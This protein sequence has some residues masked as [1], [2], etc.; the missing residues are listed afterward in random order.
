[1]PDLVFK[2]TII[3]SDNNDILNAYTKDFL[4]YKIMYI[5]FNISL[6]KMK[7]QHFICNEIIAL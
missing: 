4:F 7:V 1:V 2:M 6:N 5:I 3:V